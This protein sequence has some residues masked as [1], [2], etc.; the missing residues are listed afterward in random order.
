LIKALAIR[1]HHAFF[2]SAASIGLDST[3]MDHRRRI[4]AAAVLRPMLYAHQIETIAYE[5]LGACFAPVW[6]EHHEEKAGRH[7]FVENRIVEAGPHRVIA[8]ADIGEFFSSSFQ[9]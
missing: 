2:F 7:G 1:T 9:P 5:G 6:P 3:M 8:A 4:T